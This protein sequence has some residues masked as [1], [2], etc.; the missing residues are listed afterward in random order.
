MTAALT[1]DG[2]RRTPADVKTF[3]QA[4]PLA[5]GKW[6][7]NVSRAAVEKPAGI[8]EVEKVLASA[9]T[10][11]LKARALTKLVELS[12]ALLE[13]AGALGATQ[14]ARTETM[15]WVAEP[16][17]PWVEPP[18]FTGR[19]EVIDG[20]PTLVTT[21]GSF[22][23]N[24]DGFHWRDEVET[25]FAGSVVTLKGFPSA[26][27]KTL[28]FS[29]FAPG[30][31]DEFVSGR[32]LVVQ[33]RVYVAPHNKRSYSAEV[34]DPE[35][36]R[37]LLGDPDNNVASYAAAGVILPGTV[38]VEDGNAIF[39]G[40]A[41]SG[42]YLLGRVL[43]RAEPNTE[44]KLESGYNVPSRGTVNGA[45]VPAELQPGALVGP[46]GDTTLGDTPDSQGRRSFFFVKPR[47]EAN[48]DDFE[49]T[50]RFDL[51]WA[52][53]ASDVGQHGALSAPA[54]TLQSVA[55][56]VPASSEDAPFEPKR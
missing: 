14:A 36:K 9:L 45:V 26:D 1:F 28:A 3:F 55:D 51:V 17:L 42:F 10:D 53:K 11:E 13:L 16:Q 48:A 31:S 15:K 43:E 34:T 12:P 39:K 19:L 24:Y 25:A 38:V 49:P 46:T 22:V 8:S 5:A 21:R 18:S 6:L 44:V 40:K 20:A 23:I 7:A 56:A 50:R 47:L 2:S 35:L 4:D 41:E 52:G 37:L 33:G 27:G 54:T 32:V 29:Q 30:S